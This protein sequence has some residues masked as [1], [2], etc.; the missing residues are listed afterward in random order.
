MSFSSLHWLATQRWVSSV[1]Q[2]VHW[3]S[4]VTGWISFCLPNT[5]RLTMT[6]MAQSQ[7]FGYKD[8]LA[9]HINDS[10]PCCM[11]WTLF[12]N[13]IRTTDLCVHTESSCFCRR[14]HYM[15]TYLASLQTLHVP[16]FL[17]IDSV[18][19]GSIHFAHKWIAG[20]INGWAKLLMASFCIIAPRRALYCTL[21][22]W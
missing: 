7:E 20:E 12:M 2:D 10:H 14:W 1:D 16:L 17:W 8:I 11:K 15:P 5:L 3:F 22:F 13:R 18:A 21:A 19:D 4:G 9:C 6:A